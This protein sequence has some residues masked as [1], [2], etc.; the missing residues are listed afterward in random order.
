M[1]ATS[2]PTGKGEGGLQQ[3][4][5]EQE[6]CADLISVVV[7]VL[8]LLVGFRKKKFASA[9][10]RTRARHMGGDDTTPVLRTPLYGSVDDGNP[11]ALFIPPH[12]A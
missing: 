6:E 7:H 12:Y 8:L 1:A 4:Q 10:T 11:L 3:N 2:S 5:Q 9:G